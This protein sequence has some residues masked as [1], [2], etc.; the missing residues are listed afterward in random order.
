MPF[1]RHVSTVGH[2]EKFGSFAIRVCIQFPH[3]YFA[4]HMVLLYTSFRDIPN[5]N[6]EVSIVIHF[7]HTYHI[8]L[9]FSQN[10]GFRKRKTD[11]NLR[12]D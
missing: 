5:P 12:S 2:L 6:T 7:T 11:G 10:C 4:P 1:V 3:H 8:L 9:L